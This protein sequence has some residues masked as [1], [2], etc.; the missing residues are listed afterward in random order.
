MY[1]AHALLKDGSI[2]TIDT[3]AK[4][5]ILHGWIRGSHYRT[6]IAAEQRRDIEDIFP[7]IWVVKGSC[8]CE[9]RH[10][11]WTERFGGYRNL[12]ELWRAIEV[13]EL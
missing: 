12:S 2:I 3:T 10:P 8:E 6:S 7:R 13:I 9:P 11:V 5:N 1:H 4:E